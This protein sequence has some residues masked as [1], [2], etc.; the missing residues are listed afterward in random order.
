MS[1]LGEML[2]SMTVTALPAPTEA[3]AVLGHLQAAQSELAAATAVPAGSLSD[4]ELTGAVS[5]AAV[6]EAQAAAIK[7]AWVAE[8]DR[9]QLAAREAWA[10]TGAWAAA[11]TGSRGAV[12]AGGLWLARLLEE[13]YPATR[14]AF[15]TGR[16]NQEQAEAI[17]K[18][19]EKMPAE[20]TA[21]Q[22]AAAEADLVDQAVH[23]LDAR[24]LR[25]AGRRMLQ[26]VSRELADA[27][28]AA[29]LASEEAVA[30]RETFFSMW[31]NF[32]GTF[33]GKFTIPE[34]HAAM[35]KAYFEKLTAPRRARRYQSRPTAAGQP[36]HRGQPETPEPAA[37]ST[38]PDF[39]TAEEQRGAAFCELIE[40]LPATGHDRSAVSML[41]KIDYQHLLD[42]LASAGLD[43]GIAISATQARR[44][45]CE[46]GIIPVVFGT[47]SMPLD[48]GR[49]QRLHT[50][51]QRQALALIYDSCATQGCD[52][53]F[54]WCEIHHRQPWSH[55]GPT[56][57]DNG[58]PLCFWH[59]QRAHD[60]RFKL[61]YH[62]GGTVTYQ[63][64]RHRRT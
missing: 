7:L 40:H 4:R 41:V 21:Q 23:G 39:P 43:T 16:I 45:A 9:R 24:G 54:A 31:D 57:L 48:L 33:S 14:D 42:G 1:V 22:R 59:H 35:L 27:H 49:E 55:G 29:Q 32:D 11:L 5:A 18:A 37:D 26:V 34:L 64:I 60:E 30:E 13:T 44:L 2:S 56:N 25:Q 20:V 12:M 17:V 10:S 15:A 8:A 19:A 61:H 50:R 46:A 3:S 51:S 28:E 6:L 38:D 62:R 47:D 53:P 36:P 58:I 52:R 63:R